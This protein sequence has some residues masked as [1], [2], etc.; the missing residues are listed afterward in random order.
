MSPTVVAETVVMVSSLYFIQYQWLK[1]INKAK[2]NQG[3]CWSSS[4]LSDTHRHAHA[5]PCTRTLQI[6]SRAAWSVGKWSLGA[7]VALEMLLLTSW[8]C[9]SAIRGRR[10]YQTARIIKVEPTNVINVQ[11]GCIVET[12]FLWISVWLLRVQIKWLLVRTYCF[13]L[14]N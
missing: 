14:S 6:K 2:K 12:H 11:S 10:C 8:W 4:H 13:S 5:H 1:N 7:S 3:I 9:A